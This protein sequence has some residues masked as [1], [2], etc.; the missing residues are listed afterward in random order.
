M[1]SAHL[2]RLGV[3]ASARA[4]VCLA[5]LARMFV[6]TE[7]A[8]VQLVLFGEWD[9]GTLFG[10]HRIPFLHAMQSD[11]CVRAHCPSAQELAAKVVEVINAFTSR[12]AAPA[13]VC[14]RLGRAARR[15]APVAAAYIKKPAPA[16]KKPLAAQVRLSASP[17]TSAESNAQDRG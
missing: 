7:M 11:A 6:T 16:E 5:P 1:L 15:L 17:R 12:P 13:D 14:E 3:H 2:R 8:S 9:V 10:R 4:S